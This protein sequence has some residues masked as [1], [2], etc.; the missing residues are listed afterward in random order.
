MSEVNWPLRLKYGVL[1]GNASEVINERARA[2]RER[3]ERLASQPKDEHPE[4]PGETEGGGSSDGIE[5]IPE[6]PGTP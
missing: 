4:W 2:D 6:G 1:T 3:V 5:R